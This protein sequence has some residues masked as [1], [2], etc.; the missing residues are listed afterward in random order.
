MFSDLLLMRFRVISRVTLSLEWFENTV[1][2]ISVSLRFLNAAL[3][4]K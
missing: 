4:L 1:Q 3:A 2:K